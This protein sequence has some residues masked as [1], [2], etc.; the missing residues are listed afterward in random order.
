[1]QRDF[2]FTVLY[3]V[4]KNEFWLFALQYSSETSQ[5]HKYL[6]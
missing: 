4:F 6:V 2:D 3:D 5:E 1:M